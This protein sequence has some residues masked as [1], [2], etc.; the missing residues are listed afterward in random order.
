MVSDLYSDQR[1]H[2]YNGPSRFVSYPR[3]CT[4]GGGSFAIG[5]GN[6]RCAI[7]G[8]DGIGVRICIY[9]LN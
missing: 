3:A 2:D 1:T 4:V 7:A 8:H 6:S 5:T 9:K